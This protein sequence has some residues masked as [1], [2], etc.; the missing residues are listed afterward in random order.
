MMSKTLFLTTTL[1]LGL[2]PGFDLLAQDN[3]PGEGLPPPALPDDRSQPLLSEPLT[4]NSELEDIPDLPREF[5]D[6]VDIDE[7]KERPNNIRNDG[8]NTSRV[9]QFN[10]SEN[11]RP[12]P[13]PPK[14]VGEEPNADVNIL[15]RGNKTI[16][17]YSVYGRVY[18]VKVIPDKG[19]SYFYADT[20]GDGQLESRIG[21]GV[22]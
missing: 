12:E 22:T 5:S 15:R 1:I 9:I 3:G 21:D 20:D 8:E 13:L 10:D 17:E 19:V 16:E 18:L 6:T 7:P 11:T 2:L 4:P 14:V